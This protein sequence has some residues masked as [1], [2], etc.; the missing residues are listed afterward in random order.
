MWEYE[1][2][3]QGRPHQRPFFRNVMED[4]M[5][6]PPPPDHFNGHSEV[7]WTAH[8]GPVAGACMSI[9]MHLIAI[10]QGVE[11]YAND[12]PGKLKP[13]KV[14]HQRA[15]FLRTSTWATKVEEVTR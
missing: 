6:T 9:G 10:R 13:L 5:Q 15:H 4:L 11:V 12:T 7:T 3:Q 8:D 2:M 1:Q 14:A